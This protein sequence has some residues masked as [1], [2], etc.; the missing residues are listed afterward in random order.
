MDELD[1]AIADLKK[2]Y[3]EMAADQDAKTRER[4]NRAARAM[5]AGALRAVAI[6]QGEDDFPPD[7]ERDSQRN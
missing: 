3:A 7:T 6:L 5:R 1:Q 4:F 2:A